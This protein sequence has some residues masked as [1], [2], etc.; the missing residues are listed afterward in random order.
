[1]PE[2]SDSNINHLNALPDDVWICTGNSAKA[3][4]NKIL[5]ANVAADGGV[6][7]YR[8]VLYNVDFIECLDPTLVISEEEHKHIHEVLANI[9]ISASQ[10]QDRGGV[11]VSIKPVAPEY[12]RAV[13]TLLKNLL[14]SFIVK[15]TGRTTIDIFKFG[16]N[17]ATLLNTR[18]KSQRVTY[19]GDEHHEDGNDF[20]LVKHPRVDFV[21][22]NSPKDTNMFLSILEGVI[23]WTSS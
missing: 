20:C 5:Y 19:L 10:I 9:G 4:S 8:K 2:V 23:K 16:S 7:H 11:M 22:V 14:P 15:P 1:M 13:S 21:K 12:R 3:L 6:N 18:L 17:K